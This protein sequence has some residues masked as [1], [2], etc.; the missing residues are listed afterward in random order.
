MSDFSSTP[1]S[2]LSFNPAEHPQRQIYKL[3]TGIIV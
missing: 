2:M 3:M 1:K